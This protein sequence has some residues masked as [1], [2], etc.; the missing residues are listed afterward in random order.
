MWYFWWGCR[1]NLKLI[2][3]GSERVKHPV[4][5]CWMMLHEVW[6]K[7][8][9]MQHHP[10]SC[11]GVFKR[12]NTSRAT[13]L[14][15]VACTCCVQQCWTMLHAH[16][17]CNNVGR[18]CMQHVACNNVGRCCMQ[19]VACNNVGRCCVQQCWTMLRAT[20]LDDVAC[21]TSRATMLDD[22]ACNTSR[23]TMLDDVACNTS[24]AT[25][26]TMLHAT[27]R[28][29]QC[30]T[31]LHA[32]RRVQQCWTMLHATRRVSRATMLDDVHATRRVQQCWTMLHATRRVQQCW[33]MLHAT[34]RVQQ[35]WTMLHATC[36]VRLNGPLQIQTAASLAAQQCL[37]GL[38]NP[39]PVI[40]CHT[41]SAEVQ[42][43]LVSFRNGCSRCSTG[44][45]TGNEEV[46]MSPGEYCF[47][48]FH[49]QASNIC[50]AVS[51][52]VVHISCTDTVAFR[53]TA[54][55]RN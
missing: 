52:A 41:S 36:C 48:Q 9:F 7:S 46:V 11:N 19:H 53:L 34:R 4:A 29:Q 25:M 14:D 31:M 33:T 13:M 10:T 26:W 22:V 55:V 43:Y 18:C 39:K 15:D 51:E 45:G 23:A 35:C 17:A 49:N 50:C 12:C 40:S 47:Y 6:T 24:R 38:I 42:H 1:G 27:R 2:T 32:T 37:S 28:V 54:S 16:V 8:N 21:N 44:G 5:R 3:L 30:W 20:M